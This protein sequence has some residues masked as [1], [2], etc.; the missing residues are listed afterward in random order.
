MVGLI[1]ISLVNSG[2][3]AP[4]LVLFF[5]LYIISGNTLIQIFCSFKKLRFFSYWVKLSLYIIYTRP[6]SDICV[7]IIFSHSFAWCF[8]LWT[9]SSEEE[10]YL[11]VINHN[12]SICPFVDHTFIIASK[13]S[14]HNPGSQRCSPMSYGFM[15]Y[16]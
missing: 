1:C 5:Y 9:V 16:T 14:L 12:L 2:C 3:S 13:K 10:K 7:A 15:T 4:F 8:N 11:I 6:S